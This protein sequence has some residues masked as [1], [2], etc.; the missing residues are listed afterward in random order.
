MV[1]GTNF[2]YVFVLFD[3]FIL[4]KCHHSDTTEFI[5]FV[6]GAPQSLLEGVFSLIEDLLVIIVF[7]FFIKVIK[8]C[9]MVHLLHF[10]V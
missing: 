2:L 3:V 1:K 7:T 6:V 4:K 8:K 10:T 5:T 9:M